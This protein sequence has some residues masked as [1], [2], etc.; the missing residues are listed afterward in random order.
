MR[1]RLAALVFTFLFLCCAALGFDDLVLDLDPGFEIEAQ[2]ELHLAGAEWNRRTL[3]SHRILF[4]DDGAPYA[5]HWGVLAEKPPS[6]FNGETSRSHR[7]IRIAPRPIG[8][9]PYAVA[10][11]EYGHAHGLEHICVSRNPL[12]RGGA[13]PG[14]PPCGDEPMGV[15]DPDHVSTAFTQADLDECARVGACPPTK[16]DP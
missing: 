14:A 15:M 9:S 7:I 13:A 2:A 3:T 12:A 4:T 6:G 11:H 10:L 16:V 1:R 8:A 5:E